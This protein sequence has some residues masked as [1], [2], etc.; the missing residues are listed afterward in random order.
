MRD[1][2]RA[3]GGK[4]QLARGFLLQGR[5]DERG[6]GIALALFFLDFGNQ[7]LAVGGIEQRLFDLKGIVF[8]VD[9]ELIQLFA[10]IVGQFCLEGLVLCSQV[11][12]DGP[13]FPR[14]EGFNFL[15]ALDD[16]T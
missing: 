16:H 4:A 9:A 10:V 2:H 11:G 15:F 1:H 5:G 13:V 6:G 14:F 8:I 7:Q 3:F 12:V